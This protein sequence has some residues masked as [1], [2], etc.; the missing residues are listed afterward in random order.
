MPCCPG[1]KGACRLPRVPSGGLVAAQHSYFHSIFPYIL[2]LVFLELTRQFLFK[3]RVHDF[4]T[5]EA[6]HWVRPP[7]CAG[8]ALRHSRG[9]VH[10][11]ANL[12]VTAHRPCFRLALNCSPLLYW[13]RACCKT[14]GP[15]PDPLYLSL[16]HALPAPDARS[17]GA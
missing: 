4:N 5:L 2:G 14:N 15:A 11:M 1:A 9:T 6:L 10:M 3:Y 17:S 13:L 8:V 16:R 7:P 12:P